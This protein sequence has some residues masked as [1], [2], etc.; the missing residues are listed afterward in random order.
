LLL[1]LDV[2]GL[3]EVTTTSN[4]LEAIDYATLEAGEQDAEQVLACLAKLGI[5]LGPISEKL[6]GNGITAFKHFLWTSS[7][8]R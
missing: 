8:P 3:S 1:G 2:F 7:W 4:F 5:D 6:L